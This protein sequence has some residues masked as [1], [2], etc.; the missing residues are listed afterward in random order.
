MLFGLLKANRAWMG[1]LEAR[2]RF[3]ICA[4]VSLFWT[5]VFI[6]LQ[7]LPKLTNMISRSVPMKTIVLMFVLVPGVI[8]AACIFFGMAWYCWRVDDSNFLV[9]ALWGMLFLLTAWIGAVLYFVFVYR[10]RLAHPNKG[11]SLADTAHP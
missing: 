3:T 9:K 4:V 1:S 6:L 2:R 5:L 10:P 11:S 8:C 7:F